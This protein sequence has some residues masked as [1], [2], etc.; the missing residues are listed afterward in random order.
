[1]HHIEGVYASYRG[2]SMWY[3]SHWPFSCQLNK[4]WGV[5][6]FAVHQKPHDVIICSSQQIFNERLSKIRHLRHRTPS[7]LLHQH[8]L[9]NVHM[10][11]RQTLLRLFASPLADTYILLQPPPGN[12]ISS[13]PQYW[14]HNAYG[15]KKKTRRWISLPV[16]LPVLTSCVPPPGPSTASQIY[17][18]VQ[19]II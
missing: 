17:V 3:S 10:V 12:T 8:W 15:F 6:R 16:H 11:K 9:H 7:P 13:L 14:L 19:I 5:L 1:M 18:Q 2:G 4:C